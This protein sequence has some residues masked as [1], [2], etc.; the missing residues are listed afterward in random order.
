MNAQVEC[1]SG[2]AYAERPDAFTWEGERLEVAEVLGSWR[3]P[4]GKRFRVRTTE[5]LSFDLLY[6]EAEDEWRIEMIQIRDHGRE[7]SADYA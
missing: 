4:D 1:H 5:G 7:H 6:Q 3:T 2:Y